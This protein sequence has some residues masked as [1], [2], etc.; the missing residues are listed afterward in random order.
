MPR[1]WRCSLHVTSLAGRKCALWLGAN[2]TDVQVKLHVPPLLRALL[3]AIDTD[4]P[5]PLIPNEPVTVKFSLTPQPVLLQTGEQLRFD[6]GRT[7]LLLSDQSH[8]RAQFQMQVPPYFS[9]NNLHYGAETYIE[10]RKVP[11]QS[12]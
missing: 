5:E 6:V 10:L 2:F 11:T 4:V 3:I 1:H 8:G 12:K 7:D 9:R